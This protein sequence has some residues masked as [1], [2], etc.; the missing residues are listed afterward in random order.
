MYVN[1][2]LRSV[3]TSPG[4][5]EGGQRRMMEVVNSAMKYCK[6]FY[7]YHNVP[8]YNNNKNKIE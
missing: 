7:K 2:K 4:M 3:K 6:N 5:G 8:Q 1:G